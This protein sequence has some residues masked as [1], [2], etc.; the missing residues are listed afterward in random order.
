M[1]QRAVF[2]V[3][4]C[5]ALSG[6]QSVGAGSGVKW[7]NPTTWFS[8]KAGTASAKIEA[9]IDTAKDAAI[10]AAKASAHETQEALQVAPTSRA[11]EVAKGSN[12]N[13]VAL[14][15]QVDGPLSAPDAAKIKEKVR[16]LTSELADERAKGA[17][18]QADNQKLINSV[19]TQ[20]DTLADAKKKADKDLEAAFQR[21]NGLANQLRNEQWWS[22]FW[23]ISI[24]ALA[25][26]AVAAWVYLRF[27]IGGVPTAL[28]K[29]LANLR[30][31]DP[32]AADKLASVLDIHL[33]PAEQTMIR[34]LA[35]KHP[36]P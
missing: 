6:C 7:Y 12:D 31:A 28:G 11:V 17:V 14:L 19:S 18:L 13:T 16:L 27:T 21:E 36:S 35:A 33:S 20:L 3:L 24:G 34:L 1:N 5:L 10:T 2:V 15:D 25:L 22:W 9:K 26:I 4:A 8:G 30:S 32:A 29:S 23:R